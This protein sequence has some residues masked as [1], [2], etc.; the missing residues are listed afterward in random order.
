MSIP[1]PSDAWIKAMME[2]LNQ[3]QAYAEAAKNWEGDFYFIIEPGGSLD[4]TVILY[5][6]LWH[7]KCREAFEVTDPEAR[8]PAFRLSGP[9]QT[10]KKVMTRQL[11]PM[12]AMMTGQLRLQG[13]M[14]MV[15]KNV[16]AAKEL[17]ESCT[18]I[19]TIF[20]V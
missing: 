10:W 17:V 16:R 8:K 4:H 2:D 13:N 18:R 19:P 3:S 6:D 12:Q 20:P 15:M 7:G 5:M 1:F 9:V 14:A 11:D